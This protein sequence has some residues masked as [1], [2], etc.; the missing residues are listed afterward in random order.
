MAVALVDVGVG[1]E[2]ASSASRGKV[3][4][5]SFVQRFGSAP[6]PNVYFHVLVPEGL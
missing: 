2:G 5:V 6:Q 1:V 4:P 3:R